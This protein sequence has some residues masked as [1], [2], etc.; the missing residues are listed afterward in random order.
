MT[1][2][3]VQAVELGLVD[4]VSNAAAALHAR[5][6]AA[7]AAVQQ[8]ALAGAADALESA[9]SEAISLGLAA[10]VQAAEAAAAARQQN[11]RQAVQEAVATGSA[12]DFAARL[13]VRRS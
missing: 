5:K 1:F 3:L 8:H 10:S 2:T 13:Q 12:A 7:L 6:S 4:A 9:R 11:V